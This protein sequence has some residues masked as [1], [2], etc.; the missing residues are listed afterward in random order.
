MNTTTPTTDEARAADRATIA[1]TIALHSGIF[2]GVEAITPDERRIE[3]LG[4]KPADQ[5]LE[6]GVAGP[7]MLKTMRVQL[8]ELR[9]LVKFEP[10][11]RLDDRGRPSSEPHPNRRVEMLLQSA[12]AYAERVR[13]PW[14]GRT[15]VA[16]AIVLQLV[17]CVVQQQELHEQAMSELRGQL[18]AAAV[19]A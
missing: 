9:S 12:E 10:E 7:A 17:S 16:G 14:D 1:R 8:E 13:D 6:A 2:R 19:T 4:G 11:L 5:L 18:A 3:A 15:T